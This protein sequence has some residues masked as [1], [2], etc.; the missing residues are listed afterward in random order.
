L[1][2]PG[3][4]RS[5]A[6]GVQRLPAS[7]VQRSAALGGPLSPAHCGARGCPAPVARRSPARTLRR[8][9][10]PPGSR[11]P[12]P[13]QTFIFW[14][15]PLRYFESA[16]DRYGSRFTLRATGH[17]PLVFLSDPKD[18]RALFGAPPEVLHPGKGGES[19][20]PIVGGRSFMMLDREEHLAGR[21]AI[22]PSFQGR[23]VLG[24]GEL[25]A[26]VVAREV[27]SWPRDVEFALHPRLRALTLEIVLRT[28]FGSDIDGS[29]RL[30][31]DRLL[32][33]LSITAGPLLAQP[34]LRHGPG[35]VVWRR[36]LRARA[37]VDELIH[38]LIERARRT[39]GGHA[40][41]LGR[42]LEA[43]N[44]DGSPMDD[45]QLRDNVMS[46]VLAG[47]ET[48]ASELAWI[49]QLLAHHPAVLARLVAEIDAG[50][51]DEYLTATIQ[52]A[53]RHRPVFLFTIPRA[54]VAP[55]EI[56]GWTYSPPTRLLG[57]IYLVHHD[58]AR[59]REPYAF[60][61]ERFL[62]T[63]AG[64]SGETPAAP[65]W[66]P[67][68]GGRRRCPGLHMATLEMKT[69]LRTVLS[70]VAVH[71]AGRMERARWRSVVVTPH[72]GSRVVLRSRRSLSR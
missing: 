9:E 37:E 3:V 32:A 48:T 43:R 31:A 33:M 16:R 56:G 28:I 11:L 71:P 40:G 62:E 65:G 8:S 69:V 10:L 26:D 12:A 17:P 19:I 50:G 4:Q 7:G 70:M 35:C 49:F 23:V 54:V 66:L 20:M 55:I 52:E 5:A 18:L 34:V 36:F 38:G 2:V 63:S 44:G 45:R 42:L 41:I 72:A 21:R 6:S 25:V 59:Y 68:G 24:H 61:P 46:I 64:G 14:R 51:D 27:A 67:W 1:P 22:L 60:R 47:H 29:V 30:L 53:L 58:R 13:L 39:A 15:S 57:C